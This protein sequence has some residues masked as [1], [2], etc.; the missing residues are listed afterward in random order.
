MSDANSIANLWSVMNQMQR[1]ELL[2]RARV[3]GNLVQGHA[4]KDW[5]NLPSNVQG[6]LAGVK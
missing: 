2:K 3:A 6:Q 1:A 5:T 4:A